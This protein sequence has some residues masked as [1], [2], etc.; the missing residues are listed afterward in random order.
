[1]NYF[2]QGTN[3]ED[4]IRMSRK[5][6]GRELIPPL[7]A[8]LPDGSNLLEVGM[9]P[10]KDLDL[11]RKHYEVTGS[12]SAQAFLE[13]YRGKNPDAD[14]LLLDAV[15]L[16]TDRRFYGIFSN[17]VLM[18]LTREALKRSFQRQAEL[19]NPGGIAFHTFWR[20]E[21]EEIYDGLRFVY[22]QP[23]SMLDLITPDFSVIDSKIYK[24][25]AKADSFYIILQKVI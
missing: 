5:Y 8:H 24:E 4:Y 1:M 13:I 22:Y 15:T 23:D 18:H 20:G 9:G 10:G 12:D 11:L 7:R 16:D 25:S 14:L 6:D 17:K 2:D 21:K 19:L 3:A